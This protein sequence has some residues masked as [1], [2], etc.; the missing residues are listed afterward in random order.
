MKGVA[1]D[2][3]SHLIGRLVVRFPVQTDH[4]PSDPVVVPTFMCS[5][6]NNI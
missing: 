4:T 1:V 2:G 3:S 5:C 6:A